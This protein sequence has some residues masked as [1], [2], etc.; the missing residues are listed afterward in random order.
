VGGVADRG[1]FHYRNS[2]CFDRETEYLCP[3]GERTRGTA[4]ADAHGRTASYLCAHTDIDTDCSADTYS[5]S[6]SYGSAR[7]GITYRSADTDT[8]TDADQT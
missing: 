5:D 7:G 2:Y 4:G 1:V 6:R 3:Y 8:G